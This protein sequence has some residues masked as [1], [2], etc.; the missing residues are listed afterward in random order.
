M[1]GTWKFLP[2]Y[3]GRTLCLLNKRLATRAG[4]PKAGCFVL[5][6]S[7]LSFKLHWTIRTSAHTQLPPAPAS[8][9]RLH[10]RSTHSYAIATFR[11]P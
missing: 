2:E 8:I 1:P 9:A 5:P 6:S 10:L 7:R 3:L 4:M 11:M